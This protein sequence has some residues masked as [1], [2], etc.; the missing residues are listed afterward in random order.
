MSPNRNF[1]IVGT[2]AAAAAVAAVAGVPSHAS[3][4]TFEAYQGKA[5][6]NLN[7]RSTP[8]TEQQ[9]IGMLKKNQTFDVV[10][11]DKKSEKGNWL[12]IKYEGR[13]A[14]VDGYYVERVS[15]TA[16]AT[17][18]LSIQSVT[19]YQGVTSANLN[20]RL[21]PS[22]NGTVL[23]TLTKGTTVTVTGKTGDGW[24][25]IKYKDGSAYVSADY[26][27]TGSASETSA[28]ASTQTLYTGTTTANLNVRSGASTSGKLLTTLKKGSGVEV[29]GTSGNWLKIK[30]NGGT[31][32]V[33]GD[34]VKN[35]GSTSSS[36]SSNETVLYTGTTTANLNVRSGASTSNK[37]MATLKKGSSVEVVGTSGNWLKIKY[38][39]GTAYVS[40]DYVKKPSSENSPGSDSTSETVLYTGTTT[41]NL[42]V[43]SGAS[44]SGKLL[45]TLKKGSSVEVVGTEG[46]WLKVKY[47]GGTAYVSKDYV[48]KPS[49]ENSSGS[50]ST[51]ETVLYTGTTTAN[52][53]V[54][55][56]ASTSGKLLTTLKKGSSVEVVGT[57]GD[58]LKV[59]YNGGTAYVS[60]DYVK[61][62]SSENSSGSDST[63]ETVL[64][65]GTTTANL[66][67]RSSASTSGKLLTTLKKGSSVEVVGTEGDWLKIKYNG[68]TAYVSAEFVKKPSSD[69]SSDASSDSDSSGSQ[70]SKTMGLITTGVNFRQGPGTSYK[71]YGVL[72]AGTLVEMLADAPDGW[73][74]VSYDGKDGYVYGDYLKDETTTTIQDGNAAYITTT[75][76]LSFGQALAKEQN[77]NSSSSIAQYLNPKNFTKG[78]I[79]YYQFL[80]LSSLTNVSLSDMNKMLSGR[81]ILS[82]QGAAFISAANVN[83]VNEVYLVSHA[84]LETGNGSSTLANG[85]NYNGTTVYNMFGIGAYDGSAVNSGAKYAYEQGWTTPAKAIEGGAAWIAK[86]Y[87]YN[88]TYRQDTLYK[89][90]WNPEALVV[91]SA[92]HQ[93]AT[94]V[95]WAVKQ[96]PMIDSMYS[97]I[98]KYSL[99]FDV[100]EYAN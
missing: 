93:Y 51:S 97:T 7:I 31:A 36:D 50:D 1:T 95:G 84:L 58:W 10:G 37:I 9:Q 80:Q 52:L 33:S 40:K 49:S 6:T 69:T 22:T 5:K 15:E 35:A 26:I 13:T 38:N 45:T 92:A 12:K 68:G 77:V 23:K 64:Y 16:T 75:Y 14:Y 66:N 34:Y 91:G 32:Y 29:V 72:K 11:I 98:S 79:E 74:K 18:T 85:V 60:K 46:D 2:F 89:M 82:G 28:P 71:S 54:R 90:R 3:A 57:E 8:G 87:V 56:S 70:A 62:P 39:G 63:S 25:Q 17:P 42:N 19:N 47:N 27:K 99:I 44:T 86:Y 67:V 83:K 88:A 41:A 21:L 20:V 81:G 100:P 76:P 53:N 55:S 96:T 59:K 4:D 65:T 78:S 48:K 61:K 73:K 30:Y 43:R 94:D 24:L